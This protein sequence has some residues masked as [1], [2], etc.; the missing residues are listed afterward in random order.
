[1]NNNYYFLALLKSKKATE[2]PNKVALISGPD[3]KPFLVDACIGQ[4][5]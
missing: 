2:T 1:M 3:A 4:G 5:V